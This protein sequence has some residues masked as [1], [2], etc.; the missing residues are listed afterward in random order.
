MERS[1]YEL[2]ILEDDFEVQFCL[3]S[4]VSREY[5][6]CQQ[7][8]VRAAQ[9][10]KHFSYKQ[11]TFASDFQAFVLGPVRP[12]WRSLTTTV[13]SGLADEQFRYS[14]SLAP[15]SPTHALEVIITLCVQLN[16]GRL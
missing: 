2:D 11:R 9:I 6:L 12:G 7:N 1:I 10:P 14:R 5:L 16:I 13:P 3:R 4:G 15:K 8:S